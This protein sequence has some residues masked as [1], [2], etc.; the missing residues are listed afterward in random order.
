M[1]IEHRVG[2]RACV[3]G[4]GVGKLMRTGHRGKRGSECTCVLGMG[5]GGRPHARWTWGGYRQN[6]CM[7]AGHQ[8]EGSRG[9]TLRSWH[10]LQLQCPLGASRRIRVPQNSVLYTT[11]P[12][13]VQPRLLSR[14]GVLS[15]V[16]RQRRVS[17]ALAHAVMWVQ[18]AQG[19]GALLRAHAA[20]RA[21]VGVLSCDRGCCHWLAKRHGFVFSPPRGQL[22]RLR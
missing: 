12:S 8:A 10:L 21:G 14:S 6:E 2:E 17:G 16:V 4:M 7:R 15:E 1:R 22:G 13:S 3:L 20:S 19:Q 9:E 11:F 5:W 18:R